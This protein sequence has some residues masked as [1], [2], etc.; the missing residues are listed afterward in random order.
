[1]AE[2]GRAQVVPPRPA[3]PAVPPPVRPKVRLKQGLMRVVFGPNTTLSFDDMCREAARIGFQGFDLIAPAEWPTLRKHGL[4][5][6]MA[7]A[8]PVTFQDGL[9]HADAHAK[10]E[11]ALREYVD[12]CASSGVTNAISV[13][14][15]RR[16]M[17]EDEAADHAVAF[18][19]RIKGH[20]ERRRVTLCIENMNHKYTDGNFGRI[21]QV[22][23]HPQWGFDVCARVN[24]PNVKVLFDIYHAQVMAGDLAA[25]IRD[26]FQW[27]AHYHTAGVP[28]R[29]DIDHTQEINYRFIAQALQDLGYTG[30]ITHEFRPAPGHDPLDCIREAFEI[31]DV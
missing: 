24:S 22:F 19:N 3:P 15:Q 18:L 10:L 28:G 27:I 26:N 31:I 23:A 25:T 21:D 17:S 14:G 13:G 8:G 5:V 9:I 6:T 2:A 4:V 16:G 29:T 30:Y 7:G 20:L 12:M 1:M 11:P